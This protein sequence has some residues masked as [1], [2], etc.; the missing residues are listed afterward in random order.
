MI[1]EFSYDLQVKLAQKEENVFGEKRLRLY[2]LGRHKRPK[3]TMGKYG[4]DHQ[5]HLVFAL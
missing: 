5:H 4:Y 2:E 3:Q 1:Q